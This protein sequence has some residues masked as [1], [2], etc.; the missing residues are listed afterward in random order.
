MDPVHFDVMPALWPPCERRE[1]DTS[2]FVDQRGTDVLSGVWTTYCL[3]RVWPNGA[4][5]R[6]VLCAVY[7]PELHGL[8]ALVRVRASGG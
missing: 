8:G 6:K 2:G 7:I 4:Q 1:G 5:R 3:C